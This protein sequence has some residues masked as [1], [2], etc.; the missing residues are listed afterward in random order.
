MSFYPLHSLF[1]TL[2]SHPT[3]VKGMHKRWSAHPE[4]AH[5]GH[6][7]AAYEITS[8]GPADGEAAGGV[9]DGLSGGGACRLG[10]FVIC[11]TPVGGGPARASAT[12]LRLGEAG[13]PGEGR[14]L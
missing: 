2:P 8:G 3:V 7:G 6:G 4:D 10:L 11:S 12:I 9:G 14:F 1:V 5:D 13:C